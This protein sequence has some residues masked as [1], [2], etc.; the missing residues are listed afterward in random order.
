M[1]VELSSS[2]SVVS[3]RPTVMEGRTITAKL[4]LDLRSP[5]SIKAITVSVRT[6]VGTDYLRSLKEV[7]TGQREVLGPGFL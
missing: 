3:D 2:S 6:A 1:T 7:S 4:K 5:D